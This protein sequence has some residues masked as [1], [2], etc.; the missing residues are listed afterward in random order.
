LV[1]AIFI[2]SYVS[3]IRRWLAIRHYCFRW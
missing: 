2:F 1:F 3:S